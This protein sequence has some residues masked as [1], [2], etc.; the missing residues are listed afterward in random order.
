MNIQIRN[1]VDFKTENRILAAYLSTHDSGIKSLKQ[2]EGKGAAGNAPEIGGDL[3]AHLAGSTLMFSGLDH[4][5]PAAGRACL[6][7]V[8]AMRPGIY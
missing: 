7:P 2:G 3:M 5:C 8:P 1:S 6:N 4:I